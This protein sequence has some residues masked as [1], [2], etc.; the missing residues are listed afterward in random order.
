VRPRSALLASIAAVVLVACGDDGPATGPPA[1]T[2]TASAVR[3]DDTTRGRLQASFERGFATEIAGTQTP[4]AVALVRV[5]DEEW[6]SSLGVAD[7]SSRE[8][9]TA[10]RRFRI[11]SLT[12][13]FVA[14]VVLQLVDEGRLALDDPLERFVPGIADGAEVTVRDLLAMTSGVW[15]FTADKP[16]VARFDA[17][18]ALPWTVDDTVELLRD[19]GAD[20]APGEQVVYSDSNYVLLGRI[21]ER[22]T[23]RPIDEVI[24]ERILEPLALTETD[25]PADDE[26]G[27]PAPAT[28]GYLPTSDAASDLRPV[29]AITPTFAWAAGAMTSTA[30]D[31]TRWAAE[32]TDGTLLSPDLQRQRLQTRRFTGVDVDYGYGLGV[33]S[34]KDMFGH[35]GGIVGFGAVV[36]RLPAADATFVVLVNSSTNFDNASLDIFNALLGELYPDQV[37]LP[38]GR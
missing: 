6:V 17:D 16:L 35:T 30:G 27:V 1:P 26:P 36:M 8:P 13:M 21:V 22:V 33:M 7:V 5:G 28:V 9:M 14:T 2:D 25:F 15:S 32:L 3:L 24:T 10:V 20:F 37:T 11:A 34:T 12:K 29:T 23:G 38:T 31:L 19:H 4:G 18:P